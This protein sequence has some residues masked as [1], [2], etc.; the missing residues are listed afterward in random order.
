M[1]ICPQ[2]LLK[3]VMSARLFSAPDWAEASIAAS[4][5]NLATAN[6]ERADQES[7]A[8]GCCV[9]LLADAVFNAKIS[10]TFFFSFF[11]L[12]HKAGQDSQPTSVL[13]SSSSA[14][15]AFECLWDVASVE[16]FHYFF[17]FY[18]RQVCGRVFFDESSG[19]RVWTIIL[20]K[21]KSVEAVL[22]SAVCHVFKIG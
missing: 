12:K 21:K 22:M 3:R 10:P 16:S 13:H 19:V 18:K 6:E 9:L 1:I 17:F 7:S 5:G 2:K 11:C 20:L 15:V 4:G 14:E 8:E